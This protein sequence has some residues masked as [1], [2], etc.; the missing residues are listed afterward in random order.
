MSNHEIE[1]AAQAIRDFLAQRPGMADTT[2][3]IH[4]WWINWQG[5]PASIDVTE[6]AVQQLEAEK[7]I[8]HIQI[9]QRIIWRLRR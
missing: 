4:H 2:E 9:N 1:Y 8:E 7:F 6:A 3:G 5:H